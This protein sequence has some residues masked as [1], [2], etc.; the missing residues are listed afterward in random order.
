MS[1]IGFFG[2]SFD[3]PHRGHVTVAHWA[4]ERAGVER[5]L[6]APVFDHPLGKQASASFDHR[7]AMC[8]LAFDAC[9]G[10]E[11]SAIERELGGASRTLRTLEILSARYPDAELRLVVGAD[12]LTEAH[13]WHRWDDIVA[14]APPLVAG[15]TGHDDGDSP[16]LFDASSSD[17]REMLHAGERP[18]DLVDPR[19]LDYIDEHGL[20]QGRP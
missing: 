6:I 12:V 11:I 10:V 16:P 5:L 19:V 3:P 8:A 17:L 4:V 18:R 20:Y 7:I 14:L 1:T 13:R 2:G 15:R 9:P